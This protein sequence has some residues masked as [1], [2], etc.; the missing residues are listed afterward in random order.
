MLCTAAASVHSDHLTGLTTWSRG[1][2][3]VTWT[4]YLQLSSTLDEDNSAFT[5]PPSLTTCECQ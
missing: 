2:A 1:G 4:N 5:T 3:K